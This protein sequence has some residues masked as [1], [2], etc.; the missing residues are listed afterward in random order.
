MQSRKVVQNRLQAKENRDNGI[1]VYPCEEILGDMSKVREFA[2]FGIDHKEDLDTIKA[3]LLLDY[4]DTGKFTPEELNAY[5]MG[6]DGYAKFFD[7]AESDVK[8][9]LTEA[10]EKNKSVG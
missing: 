6:L 1:K 2:V 8:L 10:K 4:C 7:S 3:Q 9:Y 5:R